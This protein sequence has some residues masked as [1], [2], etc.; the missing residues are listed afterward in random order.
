MNG[1]LK[2]EIKM[3]ITAESLKRETERICGNNPQRLE[4]RM[5]DLKERGSR[6]FVRREA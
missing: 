1:F 6:H 2:K 4:R 3:A 5:N